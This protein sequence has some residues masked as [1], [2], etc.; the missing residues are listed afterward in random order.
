MKY[1][2]AIYEYAADNYGLITSHEAKMLGIPNVELVK[3]AHRGRLHRVGHGVYRIIHYIPTAY[4]KYAEAIALSGR[5]S[6]VYGESVLAM[7]GLGL[8][9]PAVIIV[10]EKSRIRK[11]LPAHIRVV[12]P[13]K[14]ISEIYYEGI[15]SQS[16]FKAILE[17][18]GTVM[19][20][21]LIDAAIEAERQGLIS[22]AEAK[23]A[24]KELQ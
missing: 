10:A 9:N 19:T 13:K 8:V 11:T 23:M 1:Y 4:D 7:H 16:V 5:G 17:C 6:V 15:P 21:R 24:R 22:E 14:T 3:L 20:D 2:D 12:Y 18:R